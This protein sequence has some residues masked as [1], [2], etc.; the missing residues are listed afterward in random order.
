MSDNNSDATKR[1]HESPVLKV[2]V[3]PTNTQYL[4]K[5]AEN[6]PCDETEK[7]FIFK[8]PAVIP[9]AIGE[10]IGYCM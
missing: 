4:K 10:Y 3:S 7:V 9:K 5:E 6:D 8:Q 1:D 2:L